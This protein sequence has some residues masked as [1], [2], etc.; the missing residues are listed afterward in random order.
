MIGLILLGLLTGVVAGFLGVGG[1]LI[2]VPALMFLYNFGVKKAIGTSLAT[3]VPTAIVGSIAHFRLGQVDTRTV[4]L[5]SLGAVVGSP[6]G[7]QLTAILPIMVIR[8]TFG[9]FLLFMAFRFLF[10]KG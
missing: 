10:G 7:A 4:L 3:I 9:L 1:G 8:R 6:L 2:M 5:L